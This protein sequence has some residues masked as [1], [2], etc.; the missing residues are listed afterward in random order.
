MFTRFHHVRCG[1]G[2][3]GGPPAKAIPAP[4]WDWL[5]QWLAAALEERDGEEKVS[6]D[7]RTL[8]RDGPDG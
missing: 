4:H 3:R 8:S 6:S 5:V 1:S 2:T 7:K